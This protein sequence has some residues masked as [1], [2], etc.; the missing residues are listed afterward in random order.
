MLD[1]FAYSIDFNQKA[2]FFGL[3]SIFFYEFMQLNRIPNGI[4]QQ[5]HENSKRSN[6]FS[7][8]LL[9]SHL[10]LNIYLRS[11]NFN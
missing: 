11:F 5:E 10:N 8:S 4:F 2:L 3:S 9:T 1:P 7:Y 6:I